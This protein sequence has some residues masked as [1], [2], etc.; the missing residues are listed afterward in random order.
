M[1]LTPLLVNIMAG[2]T[3]LGGISLAVWWI[4]GLYGVLPREHEK[5]L[6]EEVLPAHLTEKLFG[7]PPVLVIFYIVLF[8]ASIAYVAVIW[9][10]GV[11]Y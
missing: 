1:E 3:I 9:I 5:E 2:L 6:E 10:A 11:S 8:L 7:I 4:I